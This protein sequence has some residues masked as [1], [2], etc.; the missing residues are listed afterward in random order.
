MTGLGGGAAAGSRQFARVCS[1]YG[2]ADVKV[3]APLAELV[4]N[5]NYKCGDTGI[6]VFGVEGMTV[7]YGWSIQI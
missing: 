2:S 7:V 6:Y 4:A 1:Q 5:S 3:A